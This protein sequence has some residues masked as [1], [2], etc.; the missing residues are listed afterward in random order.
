MKNLF[1]IVAFSTLVGCTEHSYTLYRN[2]AV[3]SDMR[4]HVASFDAKD[5]DAYNQDNCQTAAGLFQQQP[6]IVT[7]FWCEKGSFKE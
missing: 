3:G 2:S 1:L 4:I 6:G 7:K 5:G